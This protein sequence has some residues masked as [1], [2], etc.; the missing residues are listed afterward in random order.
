MVLR[1]FLRNFI[2]DFYDTI[3]G[4]FLILAFLCAYASDLYPHL[5][6][7]LALVTLFITAI[8]F[9]VYLFA[10]Y[11]SKDDENDIK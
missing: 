2:D 10:K 7:M 9:V 11:S 5:I 6:I 1:G 8:S 4:M 3:Q